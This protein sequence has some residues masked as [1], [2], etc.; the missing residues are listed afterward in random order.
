MAKKILLKALIMT[1]VLAVGVH[2]ACSQAQAGASIKTEPA[3]VD[4]NPKAMAVM[5]IIGSGFK[6]DDRINI[7]LAKA[8]KGKDLPVAYAEA[9]ASGNFTTKMNMLSI[10]QGIF[11][12]RFK[13]GK[14]VPVGVPPLPPGKYTM[15]AKSWDSGLEASC[16]MEITAPKKK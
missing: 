1:F 6:A 4:L 10:L 15:K 7:V 14:P 11:N 9:D 16:I 13:K 5:K 3:A 2:L 8:S 12:L